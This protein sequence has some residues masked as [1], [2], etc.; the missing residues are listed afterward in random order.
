MRRIKP[1]LVK[2]AFLPFTRIYLL[3]KEGSEIKKKSCERN[4]TKET[5]CMQNNKIIYLLALFLALISLSLS[6]F[7]AYGILIPSSDNEQKSISI[8]YLLL[9]I[10][11]L[12]KRQSEESVGIFKVV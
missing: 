12:M 3:L 1:E 7:R 10:F 2:E 11:I 4:K 5:V 9:C 8:H 6:L